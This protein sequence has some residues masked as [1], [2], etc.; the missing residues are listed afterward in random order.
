MGASKD[1]LQEINIVK[2]EGDDN[3]EIGLNLSVKNGIV[4]LKFFDYDAL[5]IGMGQLIN[6]YSLK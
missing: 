3:F 2:L 5:D 1:L 4:N 6:L